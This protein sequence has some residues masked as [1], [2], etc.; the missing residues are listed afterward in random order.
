MLGAGDVSCDRRLV[1]ADHQYAAKVWRENPK[2]T[3]Y[4][5]RYTRYY[6]FIAGSTDEYAIRN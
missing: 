6:W 1:R 3:E 4:Q 2:E 5:S